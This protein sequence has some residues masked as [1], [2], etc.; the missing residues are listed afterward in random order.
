MLEELSKISNFGNIRC[1]EYIWNSINSPIDRQNLF[2]HCICNRENLSI[3]VD[4]IITLLKYLELINKD[5][6][7]IKKINIDRID[8]PLS[9]IIS[10]RLLIKIIEEGFIDIV[11]VENIR[12]DVID[13]SLTLKKVSIPIIYSGL[14][15]IMIELD[16]LKEHKDVKSL[17]VVD[18]K[19]VSYFK[20]KIKI[21]HKKFTLEE[22]KKKL[23]LNDINEEKLKS[24]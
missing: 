23:E 18:E 21:I 9:N 14:R 6:D 4:S 17:L 2:I 5:G 15:N 12:F 24:M 11:G 7:L 19:Y 13:E 10:K 16:I 20:S 22:L 8:M 3:P 1:I